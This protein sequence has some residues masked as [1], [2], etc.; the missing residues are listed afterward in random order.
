MSILNQI[1][2]I[3]GTAD[4]IKLGQTMGGARIY[5]PTHPSH[6]HP[7]A[8]VLGQKSAQ[9]LCNYYAGDVFHLP[10]K[11]QFKRVRNDLIRQE[12]HQL[13]GLKGLSRANFLAIKYG[14]SRR[15][16]LYIVNS[17][18]SMATYLTNQQPGNDDQQLRLF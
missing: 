2:E 18:H 12:Y 17:N 10:S 6:R 13:I 14:L 8:I 5:C 3:I 15:F 4:A 16:I 11:V 9:R 1:A 7:L